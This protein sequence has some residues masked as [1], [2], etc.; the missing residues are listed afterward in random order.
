MTRH[1]V[2]VVGG[3]PAGAAA[4][5]ELTR[6]GVDCLVLDRES[7]PRE[8]LCA[9]WITPDVLRDLEFEPRDYPYRFLTFDTLRISIR[10]LRFPF[11]S[12]QHS[13][14]RYEF[15]RW[16]L[17]RSGAPVRRHNVRRV[18]R[19]D[20]TYVLDDELECRWLIGAGGTRCP[21]Y[22]E[23]FR[24]EWPRARELQL[25]TQEREFPCDAGSDDCYLWF[26]GHGLPGY[27]WFVPKQNGYVNVGIGGVADKI[28]A[29]GGDIKA[30]WRSFVEDLR[31]A[32]LL[33]EDPGPPGGYSYFLRPRSLMGP[34]AREP[35]L[36]DAFLVGDSA[37]LAT[38]DM[39]EGIGPAIQSGLMAARAIADDADFD[40]GAI[41]AHTLGQPLARRVLD[42]AFAGSC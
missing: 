2:I 5:W 38:R 26:F 23:L 35:R 42:R 16:L 3:G 31:R 30:Y 34:R 19:R 27:A 29:R 4:A 10:G 18:E 39:C 15:D 24:Q 25:V 6:K 32:G 11:R 13:I 36:E 22:R 41:P 9:G 20:G 28:R 1:D 7:F 17:E 12:P 37:G 40:L 8:K 14:R 21:V 33:A